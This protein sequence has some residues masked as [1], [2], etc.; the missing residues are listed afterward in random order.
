MIWGIVGFLA[1]LVAGV[2]LTCLTQIIRISRGG[3]PDS[4]SSQGSS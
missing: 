1:G 4:N 3:R 2:V